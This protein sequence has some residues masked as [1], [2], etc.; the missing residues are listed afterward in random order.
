MAKKRKWLYK[1][2][3]RWYGDLESL[4]HAVIRTAR[5][6]RPARPHAAAAGRAPTPVYL[7]VD[8]TATVRFQGH[9]LD[10]VRRQVHLLR[11]SPTVE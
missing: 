10:D 5:A 11:D 4:L 2:D 1:K 3:G 9:G 8:G 7:V 6:A